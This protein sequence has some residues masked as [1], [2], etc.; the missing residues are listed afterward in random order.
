MASELDIHTILSQITRSLRPLFSHWL[1]PVD[2]KRRREEQ[3]L[4]FMQQTANPKHRDSVF[5]SLSP[6]SC[7][8]L[9]N[10]VD[11]NG[12][13]SV[14]DLLART[15]AAGYPVSLDS[16]GEL[17]YFGLAFFDTVSLWP[18]N[19][20]VWTDA[21]NAPR[22]V[23]PP[24]FYHADIPYHDPPDWNLNHIRAV[25]EKEETTLPEVS[26]FLAHFMD[27]AG[28]G[29]I[30]LTQ[31]SSFTA[32]AKTLLEDPLVYN[33]HSLHSPEALLDFACAAGVVKIDSTGTVVPLK[34]FAAFRQQQR[35]QEVRQYLD[36]S[37]EHNFSSSNLRDE[38]GFSV[39]YAALRSLC[40][41]LGTTGES[42]WIS[43]PQIIREIVSRIQTAF[44]PVKPRKG[45]G[46]Q[47]NTCR[48]P[49]RRVWAAVL[50]TFLKQWFLTAGVI[51]RGTGAKRVACVRLSSFGR[52]W[53][54]EGHA[55]TH[56]NSHQK[57]I[58]QPDFTALLTH[59]G[60]WDY[61]AQ[62]LGFFGARSG[63]DNASVFTFSRESVQEAMQRGHTIDKVLDILQ[64]HSS[65]PLPDNVAH[66][67]RE[68]G[69]L[70]SAVTL[71][72]DV[73]LFS[74]ESRAERDEFISAYSHVRPNPVGDRLVLIPECESAVL[75]IMKQLH[76]LPVD[77]T[78]PPTSGIEI[79]PSGR[80]LCGAPHDLRVTV[81]RNAIAVP[82][83]SPDA[84]EQDY[85]LSRK[86][87][88]RIRNGRIVYERLMRLP[89]KKIPLSIRLSLLVLL[90]LLPERDEYHV[91][92]LQTTKDKPILQ[93]ALSWR[94]IV[95]VQLSAHSF[96]VRDAAVAPVKESLARHALSAK[97]HLV[98]LTRIP[99]R[100]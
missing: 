42:T 83:T 96:V 35:A 92:E 8:L 65:Y 9:R 72:R 20:A 99:V 13:I 43:V 10:C 22:L 23:I 21:H 56:E 58:V 95:L 25:T 90:G 38:Y 79:Q 40:S 75:G 63:D 74:F 50:D 77:Y 54:R 37:I 59:S 34:S 33:I 67:L 98:P 5:A 39:E 70:S 81:L 85:Y 80:V 3:I 27:A 19:D 36:Y 69:Q 100:N 53:L 84:D 2:L 30:R 45:W 66:T 49:S 51:H 28:S 26:D 14:A 60:P 47:E 87:L 52:F 61:I 41:I 78:Q 97:L 15:A 93:A 32:R 89:G 17:H 44:T 71:H 29:Q 68:W 4:C 48:L 31:Q 12:D 94:K 18:G 82:V 55:P 1:S 24:E 6:T 7:A 88:K 76:A 91:L 11:Y 16:I 46:W 64:R 86:M 57:L 73:N 62:V